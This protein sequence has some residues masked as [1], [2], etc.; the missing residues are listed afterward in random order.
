MKNAMILIDIQN[1]YFLGGKCELYQVDQAAMVAATALEYSRKSGDEVIF[2]Q[3]INKDVHALFFCEGTFGC[4]IHDSVKPIRGEKIIIKHRPNS[5]YETE[6]EDYLKSKGINELRICG[7][8]SH[9]C[10]DTT[11]RVAKDLGYT[12]NLIENAC[13]TRD[14]S[15]DGV[16]YPAKTVHNVFMAALVGKFAELSQF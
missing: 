1:D 6:L 12:I 3:H 13:T 5:F 8:M 11:V 16:V 14:L 15:F 9:M 2:I 10:V 7:M 4:E